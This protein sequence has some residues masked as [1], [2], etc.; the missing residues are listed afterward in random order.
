M[1]RRNYTDEERAAGLAALALYGGDASKAAREVGVPRNTLL[2]WRDNAPEVV[3]QI[4]QDKAEEL[5]ARLDRIADRA[6]Q[7]QTRALEVLESG[8]DDLLLDN[9]AHVNRAMGTAIDK[10]R[11]LRGEPTE[12]ASVTV[13]YVDDWRGTRNG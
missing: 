10:A 2:R 12:N 1:A 7:L 13:R 8:A 11:L 6:A 3:R 9:W 4:G 5:T